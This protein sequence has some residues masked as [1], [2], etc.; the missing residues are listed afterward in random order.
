VITDAFD[1]YVSNYMCTRVTAR[2]RIG[3]GLGFVRLL[4]ITLAVIHTGPY[5]V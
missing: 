1:Q 3:L 2:V 5:C 4:R